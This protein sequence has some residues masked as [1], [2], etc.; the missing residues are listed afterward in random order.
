[1]E[2]GATYYVHPATSDACMQLFSAAAARG[3]AH[4]MHGK[5]V[6]T[7]IGEAYFQSRS[8][9][10]ITVEARANVQP[11]GS[12]VGSCVGVDSSTKAVVVALR[13]VKL[14]P[15]DDGDMIL[16]PAAASTG[17]PTWTFKTRAA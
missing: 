4:S 15:L 10:S 14:A 5:A 3:Q 12:I 17:S 16:M 1:V 9:A 7:Y 13:D 2:D 11:N 6:P 8:S